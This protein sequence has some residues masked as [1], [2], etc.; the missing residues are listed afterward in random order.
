MNGKDEIA[1]FRYECGAK[2]E[3]VT[4]WSVKYAI[5]AREFP[6]DEQ[7]YGPLV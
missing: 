3:C 4:P 6:K 5:A 1:G 2:E 7:K